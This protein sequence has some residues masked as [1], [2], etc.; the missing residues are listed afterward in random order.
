MLN[1]ASR[2][3]WRAAAW[4]LSRKYPERWGDKTRQTLEV[5]GVASPAQ[6]ARLVREAFGDKVT[7]EHAE[8]GGVPDEAELPT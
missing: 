7:A 6:A 3:D 4:A 2:E 5:T 1:S 8:Q